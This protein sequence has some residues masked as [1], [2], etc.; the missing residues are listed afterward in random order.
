MNSLPHQCLR[1]LERDASIKDEGFALPASFQFGGGSTNA[2][3]TAAKWKGSFYGI[4]IYI[5]LCEE[6]QAA[7][8]GSAL[9]S[10][11]RRLTR[12]PCFVSFVIICY[13]SSPPFP[14]SF[15]RETSFG[16][17]GFPLPSISSQHVLSF[18]QICSPRV[19]RTSIITCNNNL[20][21]RPHS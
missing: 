4:Y 2:I 10:I 3:W 6:V 11:N 9:M 21:S 7:S 1:K 17:D 20:T 19:T 8:P 12:T 18:S 15:F 5:G 16:K 14:H 13:H